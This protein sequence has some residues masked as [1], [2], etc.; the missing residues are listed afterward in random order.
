MATI[1]QRD[2]VYVLNYCTKS[3][4]RDNTDARHNYGQYSPDDRRASIAEAWRFPV[5]DS[6]Y[7]GRSYED[8]YAFNTVTFVLV[9]ADDAAR[10]V[11]VIGT[12]SDLV[13]PIPMPRVG[14]AQPDPVPIPVRK[15]A[16]LRII[17]QFGALGRGLIGPNFSRSQS[18]GF[19]R[20][21][22]K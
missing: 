9:N 2:D 15:T 20:R 8:S 13:T 11:A 3:L 5:I 1:V 19:Q 10:E 18:S 4:A 6:Y 7:D 22:P 12:F 14:R 21:A 17:K 16:R